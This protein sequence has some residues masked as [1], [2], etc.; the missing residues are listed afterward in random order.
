ML[1]MQWEEEITSL[2]EDLANEISVF[3]E[4]S[5]ITIPDHTALS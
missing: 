3:P 1:T 5:E 2:K 4:D